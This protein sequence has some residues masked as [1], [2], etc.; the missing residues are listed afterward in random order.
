MKF[1]GRPLQ[2]FLNLFQSNNCKGNLMLNLNK[3]WKNL[4]K[5]KML[6]SAHVV[7]R[8]ILR[9]MHK[10][11]DENKCIDLVLRDL[12]K[13]FV[14]RTNKNALDNGY[15][16]LQGLKQAI[17]LARHD[18]CKGTVLG[19]PIASLGIDRKIKY[20]RL[21]LSLWIDSNKCDEYFNRKYVY[22]FVRQD[23]SPEYQAVQG[24]H[25]AFQLG[26]DLRDQNRI[27][28][29]QSRE[30]YFTVI[31]V[32]DEDALIETQIHL[33]ERN[34]HGIGF[35]EPDLGNQIT[36]IATAPIPIR[37]RGD[38][39]QYRLLRFSAC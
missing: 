8:A 12:L 24:M 30:L 16:P 36:A 21:M 29:E 27:D 11:D 3:T 38:L 20:E 22:I 31:G 10:S 13:A 7:E 6:T 17:A 15:K 26:Y 37:E 35:R 23:I 28:W 1:V 2:L 34:I 19:V 33:R 39:L 5:N 25:A 14:P 4:H 18:T 9:V 32:K